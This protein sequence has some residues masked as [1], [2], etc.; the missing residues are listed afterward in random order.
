MLIFKNLWKV[1][2]AKKAII[3]DLVSRKFLKLIKF[4]QTLKR[5]MNMTILNKLEP[6]DLISLMKTDFLEISLEEDSLM[7]L[8]NS[9]KWETAYSNMM[10]FSKFQMKNGNWKMVKNMPR[11]FIKKVH[12]KMV[13]RLQRQELEKENQMEPF[14]RL[15]MNQLRTTK[16]IRNRKRFS[17]RHTKINKN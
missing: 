13:K 14:M 2:Q 9:I 15:L 10:I 5:E 11:N 1:I 12:G 8:K 17:T 6:M 4:F 3:M 7:K 16:V